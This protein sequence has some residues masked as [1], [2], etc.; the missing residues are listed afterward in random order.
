[1]T[2]P[3]A[4]KKTAAK[5][6]ETKPET[7]ETVP[8]DAV[9][10][11]EVKEEVKP[12]I[13]EVLNANPIIVEFANQ[14]LK[15]ADDIA[16]YN[17]EV[18]A[19]K[20]S[21]WN[22]HKVLEKAREFA[23]P[24]DKSEPDAEILDVLKKYEAAQ[25]AY[26]LARRTVLDAAA[27]KLGI[28]LS[29]TTERDPNR[30]APL[31]EGRKTANVIGQQLKSFAE[32]TRDEATTNAVITFLEANPL[33]MVGRDQTYSF[34]D[35]AKGTPKYRVHISVTNADGDEVVSEDG[36]TKAAAALTKHYERGQSP[37]TDT[38]REMW[39]KAGNTPSETKVDPVEFTDNNLTY[40]ISKK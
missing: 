35:N 18:L 29:N 30:E 6:E 19:E 22:G 23:R 15:W 9:V 10:Q 17:K 36:F 16:A 21:D 3:T 4:A 28:T 20:T 5:K 34:T 27:K 26:N 24:T 8:N 33:P 38:L 13:P 2:T 14:Y 32:M 1:M 40:K 25:D 11:E 37:K 12:R 39:E 7:V 31:K